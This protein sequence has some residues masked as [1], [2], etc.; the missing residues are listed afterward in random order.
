MQ[1]LKYEEISNYSKNLSLIKLFNF[2]EKRVLLSKLDFWIPFRV[3]RYK[4]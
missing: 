2:L 3:F 1:K 4:F